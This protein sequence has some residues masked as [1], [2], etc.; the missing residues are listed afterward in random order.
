MTLRLQN[1]MLAPFF[2]VMLAL[3]TLLLGFG[4]LSQNLTSG[5][6]Q[7]FGRTA[8]GISADIQLG[9][10]GNFAPS[11]ESAS[12][13]ANATNKGTWTVDPSFRSADEAAGVLV[14]GSYI[15][16]PTARNLSES[17]TAS[18]KVRVDGQLANGQYMYVVDTSGNIVI[19]TRGGQRM[20]HPTLIGGSN[21]Q[22]QAAGIVDIRG[23]KIYSVDN[24]SG[25]FKPGNG[26]LQS[27]E[28]AFGNLPS[29]SFHTDFQGYV[30]FDG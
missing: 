27:A 15:K 13:Y 1:L 10:L 6:Y 23:G 29:N 5:G 8:S 21:P 20:P 17:V 4:N 28:G 25:H 2:L 11:P 24:A 9:S 7:L 19:G 26:S 14:N 3:S 16:N 18:G 30:P 12:E 22:V